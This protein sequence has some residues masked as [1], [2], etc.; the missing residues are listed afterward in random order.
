MENFG[1]V[2]MAGGAANADVHAFFAEV[3]A[4]YD[5]EYLIL[6]ATEGGAGRT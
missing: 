2:V 6:Q 5:A 3:G 4:E 1:P